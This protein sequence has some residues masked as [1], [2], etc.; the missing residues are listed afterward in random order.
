[1]PKQPHITLGTKA[2]FH[3]FLGLGEI[4]LDPIDVPTHK[5]V[6]G[7]SGTGKSSFLGDHFKQMILLGHP[8]SLIDP[9]SDLAHDALRHLVDAGYPMDRYLYVDFARTDRYVPF[10]LSWMMGSR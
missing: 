5:H 6:M 10:N 2:P 1:V 7:V 8:A 9:H 3:G 4:A